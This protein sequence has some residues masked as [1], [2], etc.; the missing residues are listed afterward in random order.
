MGKR[1]Q[2]L[3][4]HSDQPCDIYIPREMWEL[5]HS[6]REQFASVLNYHRELQAIQRDK[7]GMES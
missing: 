1:A 7:D 3:Y 6:H 2:E 5:N 4:L